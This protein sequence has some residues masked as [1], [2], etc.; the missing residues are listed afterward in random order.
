MRMRHLLLA[1]MLMA[2]VLPGCGDGVTD[3][4][5]DQELPPQNFSMG[6]NAA[7]FVDIDIFESVTF[8]ATAD[9]GSSANDLD[10]YVTSTSCSGVTAQQLFQGACSTFATAT[11]RTQ[12]PER[13][14]F[15]ASSGR[16]R[17]WVANFGPGSESGTLRVVLRRR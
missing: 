15:S 11:S 17:V 9:W 8:E 1:A 16:Y 12:K 2:A 6:V 13:V 7:Q 10:I 3:P 4:D 14:T 5:D